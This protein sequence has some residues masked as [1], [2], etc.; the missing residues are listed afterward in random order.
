MAAAAAASGAPPP[1]PPRLRVV[2]WNIGLKALRN[3]LAAVAGGSMA[4]LLQLLAADIL[5][6]QETKV[7][8]PGD[9]NEAACLADG[10][11]SWF[12]SNR[13]HE[14]Y[15]GVATI[16]RDGVPVLAVEE[17][18]TGVL[19]GGG[20]AG[21]GGDDATT[22]PAGSPTATTETAAG[23]PAAWVLDAEGRCVV[24][25]HGAF[26]LFNVYMP[27]LSTGEAARYAFKTAFHEAL[28]ARVV[29]AQAAGRR[30]VV[31]GDLNVSHSRLDHC[32][33]DNWARECGMPSFESSIFRTWMT[34]ML[35]APGRAAGWSDSSGSGGGTG[36]GVDAVTASV[37]ATTTTGVATTAAAAAAD[38][39]A[40]HLVDSF[41]YFHPV[42]PGA[43]TCW[44]VVTSARATNYGTRL[45]YCLV[46]AAF[47]AGGDG[48]MALVGADI[49]PEQGGSDHCPAWVELTVPPGWRVGDGAP[50]AV[51]PAAWAT[52]LN[53]APAFGK[54]QAS[55]RSFFTPAAPAVVAPAA[56]APAAAVAAAA[57]GGAGKAGSGGGGG[58]PRRPTGS[59]LAFGIVVR[60]APSLPSAA[61]A[62][63]IV[64]ESDSGGG[65]A[66]SSR[67]SVKVLDTTTAGVMEA[68]PQ[69]SGAASASSAWSK[70]LSGRVVPP[71]CRCGV[72]AI[73]RTVV[74][75]GATLGKLFYVCVKPQGRAGDAAARCN[76]FMWQ[77]AWR[78]E[79]K[80]TPPTLA[81]AAARAAAAAVVAGDAGDGVASAPGAK[82]LR[83][84]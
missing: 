73:E 40:A 5:C 24:T 4:R 46:D 10:Y 6:L 38:S 60:K 17:G 1:P 28:R 13:R 70:L 31:V 54:R 53:A 52:S 47:L 25:D 18:I 78:D 14:P 71:L 27:A 44:N 9:L 45:D 11:T 75:A 74:K 81:V 7:G 43:Y 51:S 69:A 64:D 42:R 56:P 67:D 72:P 49:V 22:T 48:G 50:H 59:L 2:S 41:R 55:V 39:P 84:V 34:A 76:F 66:T 80:R 79:L 68:P 29:S 35:T 83:T 3:T 82:R 16:V 58:A 21:S 30:V 32:D 77:E 37:V 62:I 65:D 57:A 63:E 19:N 36:G 23:A 12:V 8:G 15:A 61:A 20:S 26:V 33:P